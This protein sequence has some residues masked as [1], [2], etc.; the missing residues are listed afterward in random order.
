MRASPGHVSQTPGSSSL[1]LAWPDVDVNADI[2]GTGRGLVSAWKVDEAAGAARLKLELARE[3]EVVRRFLL[4][5]ADGVEVYRYVLDLKAKPGGAVFQ[6][7]K[8]DTA[9]ANAPYVAP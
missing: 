6:T 4:P 3:A 2:D 5:P 9:P 8:A 1:V 7:A